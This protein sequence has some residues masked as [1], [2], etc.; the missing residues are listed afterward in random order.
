M[1]IIEITAA[2]LMHAYDKE[3]WIPACAIVNDYWD[4]KVRDRFTL[5]GVDFTEDDRI[6]VHWLMTP[7]LGN[8]RFF[9]DIYDE[10]A[11]VTLAVSDLGAE[12]REELGIQD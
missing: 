1:N 4:G 7:K 10:H 3:A 6:V 9:Q 11:T 8:K 5:D 2:T 12:L